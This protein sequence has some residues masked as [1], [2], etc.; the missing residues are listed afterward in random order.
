MELGMP[1]ADGTILTTNNFME[2]RE[3]LPSTVYYWQ[4]FHQ[5]IFW[6]RIFCFDGTTAVLVPDVS[7]EFPLMRRY[8]SCQWANTIG[9]SNQSSFMPF[10]TKVEELK[11]PGLAMVDDECLLFAWSGLFRLVFGDEESLSLVVLFPAW[12]GVSPMRRNFCDRTNLNLRCDIQHSRKHG[13]SNQATNSCVYASVLP[14]TIQYGTLWHISPIQ[15]SRKDE[16]PK[17]QKK[18]QNRNKNN[19]Q[20]RA[21]R[22]KK[23]ETIAEGDLLPRCPD[24][25][26]P[27]TKKTT[28]PQLEQLPP[29]R[30]PP[31][32]PPPTA[33]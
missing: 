3:C 31:P 6:G 13:D 17:N 14:F 4:N 18:S 29:R 16:K 7:C 26:T 28:N 15:K 9:Y 20:N 8:C 24:F 22:A 12:S 10:S 2:D 11:P 5:F 25:S 1:L 32:P 33:N 27:P 30:P 23:K 19:K 21:K